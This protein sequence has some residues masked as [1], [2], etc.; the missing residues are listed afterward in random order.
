MENSRTGLRGGGGAHLS[1]G[2]AVGGVEVDDVGSHEEEVAHLA[3]AGRGIAGAVRGR[4]RRRGERKARLRGCSFE[5]CH[6]RL[7]RRVAFRCADDRRG[8]REGASDVFRARC[9]GR[10][11]ERARRTRVASG[12]RAS[13]NGN[14]HP[15][16]RRFAAKTRHS[17]PL[18]TSHFPRRSLS[19]QKNDSRTDG[20]RSPHHTRGCLR[21]NPRLPPRVGSARGGLPNQAACAPRAGQRSRRPHTGRLSHRHSRDVL[22][23]RASPRAGVPASAERGPDQVRAS[24]VRRAG[25]PALANQG[26]PRRGRERGPG[27]HHRS[28]P[29]Q[30][31]PVR[32][33]ERRKT[34]RGTPVGAL[35]P[36]FAPPATQPATPRVL[37]NERSD[38][39]SSVI[40]PIPTSIPIPRVGGVL[41]RGD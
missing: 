28:P 40:P 29:Q 23:P 34:P 4:G 39:S 2:G 24:E 6:L 15:A 31:R 11:G 41:V 21:L 18:T 12:G 25:A 33:M 13:R 30:G 9:A 17:R 19:R 37:L 22:L 26:P 36:R 38:P 1:D 10:R 32:S 8:R 7:D 14:N 3:R 16:R 20:R 35:R 27:R 5:V